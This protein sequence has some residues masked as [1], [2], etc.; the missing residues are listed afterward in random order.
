[1]T[2]LEKKFKSLGIDASLTEVVKLEYAMK[3]HFV[4]IDNIDELRHKFTVVEDFDKAIRIVRNLIRR[5]KIFRGNLIN[6]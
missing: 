5:L 2:P 3:K 6:Q 4:Y 1:M